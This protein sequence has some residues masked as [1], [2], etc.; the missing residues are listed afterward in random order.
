MRNGAVPSERCENGFG[1]LRAPA[2]EERAVFS[3]SLVKYKGAG[4]VQMEKG[5][6]GEKV[7]VC[8]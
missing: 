5:L 8:V 2:T 3:V 6:N 1:G 4:E 7:C